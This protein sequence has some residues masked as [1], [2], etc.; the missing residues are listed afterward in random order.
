MV[1]GEIAMDGGA[2]LERRTLS[3]LGATLDEFG[4]FTYYLNLGNKDVS[5]HVVTVIAEDAV[6]NAVSSTVRV[7]NEALAD[8]VN[9]VGLLRDGEF[10]SALEL[11]PAATT[12][13]T[14]QLEVYPKP[15]A[16]FVVND[17]TQVRRTATTRQGSAKI[18]PD[19][20]YRDIPGQAFA[21][22][23][24]LVSIPLPDAAISGLHTVVPYYKVGDRVV[25]VPLSGVVDGRLVFTAPTTATFYLH[26]TEVAFYDTLGHWA[27]EF[28]DFTV[29]RGLFQGIGN[30]LFDP[31]G[32]MTRAMFATVIAR[33]DGAD[34]SQ[35]GA[36]RFGDVPSG[37]WFTGPIEWAAE[38]GIIAG[39]GDGQ[40]SPDLRVSRQE[41]AVML[42]RYLA[43]RGFEVDAVDAVG[44]DGEPLSG[45]S[46]P[47]AGSSF[48]DADSISPWAA[49]ALVAMRRFGIVL[50][51][52]GNLA[53]PQG[54]AT[55]AECSTVF[56]RLI[57][58][59][60]RG[61]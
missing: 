22:A 10:C 25:L 42:D 55:R 4:V 53:D 24:S 46:S 26:A 14:M 23:G 17:E 52:P 36:S 27:Q 30:G 35:Y 40:F 21:V 2:K 31:E 5:S 54:S 3:G 32:S 50:G 9:G 47:A 49:E 16:A 28:I 39:T 7:R 57:E 15:A 56:R 29:A 11:L 13:G 41:M 12:A 58:A 37:Q 44:A 8:Q 51:R 6:G 48:A 19:V 34:L 20:F 43:Y 59:V 61:L 33:L 38:A 60:L 1:D 45:G 18:E